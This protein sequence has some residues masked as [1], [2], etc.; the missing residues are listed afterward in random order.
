H[1]VTAVL[2]LP[3]HLMITY[4][5]LLTLMFLYMPWAPQAAYPQGGQAAY[6]AE[7]QADIGPRNPKPSGTPAPLADLAP[8]VAQAQK[9]WQGTPAE[10]ITVQNPGDAV[11]SITIGRQQGHDMRLRQ[12]SVRFDGVSGAFTGTVAEQPR[13]AVLTYDV[14]EGLHAA[15][16]ASPLLRALFFLSGLAGCA[17]VASGLLLWAVKERPLHLK[18]LKKGERGNW[19]LRLVDGLNLATVAGLLVAMPAFFWINRLLPPGAADRAQMEI[20]LFFATWAVC[21]VLG[22]ARPT[23][24]MWRAQLMAAGALF[25]GVPLLNATTGGAHWGVSIPAGLWQVAGFDAVCVL[26]GLGLL[27]AAR[28]V[29][30]RAA[31]SAK[32]TATG[33]AKS[34]QPAIHDEAL[35]GHAQPQ[36]QT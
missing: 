17:M 27:A 21:A 24:G 32:A 7:A 12:P 5:G 13:P 16:F 34:A 19:A 22:L 29:R 31:K 28:H 4:T 18:A 35:S 6:T 11:A 8:L 30:Q 14:A 33:T 23:R 25:I 9:H 15:R 20:H 10:R 2:A 1:N 26:L 3:Y 36:I